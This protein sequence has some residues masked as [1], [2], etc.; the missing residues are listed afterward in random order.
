MSSLKPA[1]FLDRDGTIN[2]D[3]G[4]TYRVEDFQ[5]EA[6]AIEGLRLLA[7]LPYLLI[8]TT[9][10]SGIGRGY[11]S[12]EDYKRFTDHLLAELKKHGVTID[13]TYHCPH[14]PEKGIG[15][16]KIDCLCRKPKA[17]MIDQAVSDFRKQG[18]EIDVPNSF[19]I[20][21]KTDDGKMGNNAGC[22][23][24]LVRCPSGKKGLDGNHTCTWSYE[25]DNLYHAAQWLQH[26]TEDMKTSHG[27]LHTT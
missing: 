13:A 24:I 25:A 7:T 6:R 1:L 2:V 20:G 9:G 5:F 26:I 10:Q 19:V 12:E 4:Y 18:I 14:H 27:R 11:Y 16:Y 17:G 3:N 8:I 23:S 21:D 22:R 15:T